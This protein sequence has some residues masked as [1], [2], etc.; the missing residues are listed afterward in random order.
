MLKPQLP[1]VREPRTGLSMGDHCELMVKEWQISR[2]AQDELAFRSHQNADRAY[3][4]GF[5]DDLIAPF[6]S[7]KRDTITRKETSLEKLAALKPAFDKSEHG[8]LTAGNS[9]PLTDGALYS[10]IEF[11]PI[12][13]S[14]SARTISLFCRL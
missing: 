5:Y 12:G 14:T 2:K 13:R 3:D 10:A 6:N 9:T 11:A 8:S 7:L 4:E 1:E